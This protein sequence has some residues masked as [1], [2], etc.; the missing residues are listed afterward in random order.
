M[1]VP[2]CRTSALGAVSIA[3]HVHRTAA[4]YPIDVALHTEDCLK[5][6]LT[7]MAERVK[8]VVEDLRGNGQT[9]RSS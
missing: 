7:A 6:K 8:Q 9:M 1:P 4:R 2:D 5:D 3:K